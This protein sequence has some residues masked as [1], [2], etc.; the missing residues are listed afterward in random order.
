MQHDG[1]ALVLPIFVALGDVLPPLA[2]LSSVDRKSRGLTQAV[3]MLGR[4][5]PR[6]GP[7]RSCSFMRLL[8]SEGPGPGSGGGDF[9][10]LR[11][12]ADC[13]VLCTSNTHEW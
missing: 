4:A 9:S 2:H 5:K 6:S 10:L 11:K 1:R 3:L 12:K 8:S 13:S 7:K